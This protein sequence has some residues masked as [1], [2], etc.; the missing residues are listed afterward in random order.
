MPRYDHVTGSTSK[1]ISLL[2]A[3]QQYIRPHIGKL[4]L[5]ALFLFLMIGV[6]LI[7]PLLLKKTIDEAFPDKN[8]GLI[9][10]LASIYMGAVLFGIVA[11]FIQN[12]ILKMFGQE[13]IYEI[14]NDV[15]HRIMTWEKDRF[16]SI[17]LG[18]LVTRLTNDCESLRNLFTDVLLKLISSA[19]LLLGIL[20]FLYRLSPEL[21]LLTAVIIPIM[22]FITVVYRKYSR[23]AFRGVRSKVA[24]SNAQVQE[25]LNYIIIVKTYLG[26]SA[27]AKS[28]KK[29]SKEYL[30]AGLFEVKT[31]AIFRPVVDSLY[32]IIVIAILSFTNWVDTALDAGTVFA[33]LQYVQ[34]IFTPIKDIAEKYT[35]LQQSLAGAER[36]VPILEERSIPLEKDITIP[37][38]FKEIKSI[39]FDHVYFAYDGEEYV[40]EDISFTI[41]GGEFLGIAGQSGSGKSTMMALL[42]GFIRPTKGHIY[43]NGED[44]TKYSPRVLRELMGFV[45]QDSHL[46]KG[47]IREN[48]ALYEKDISDEKVIEAMAD[49]HL[50]DMVERLP[51][52]MHTPVGYLGS[53]L[54]AGQ[55]QLLSLTRV[56]LQPKPILIFDEATANIDSDTEQKIQESIEKRRGE[57]TIISIAHRLST[58]READSII[59][60]EKGRIIEEGNFAR[61]LSE[62]GRFYELWR[63]GYE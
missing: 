12:Y 45:F 14:R 49:A 55:R 28:Y 53:L 6:D 35:M 58:I 10:T 19:L 2:L 51:E 38:V 46:F 33:A 42:M 16:E 9:F 61:L 44:I 59:L 37:A 8:V 54:S 34:K 50:K 39:V 22:G 15:F 24:A 17:P 23:K 7:R 60:L 26:E 25:V 5:A 11:S 62:K 43:I 18:N 52:G 41:H 13:I 31:F 63:A 3:L 32:F 4:L 36:L 57:R 27:V 48:I 29:V 47:S 20:F 30:D 40:L 56:L 1:D 21:A